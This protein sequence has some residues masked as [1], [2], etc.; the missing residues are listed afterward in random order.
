MISWIKKL[1]ANRYAKS[2][3][4]YAIAVM[5]GVLST[6]IDLPTMPALEEL[7]TFIQSALIEFL[8][9]NKEQL[10]ELL[11]A[12]LMAWLGTWTVAKNR[13]NAKIEKNLEKFGVKVK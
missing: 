3:A 2:I 13:A 5:I 12:I 7:L 9:V 8:D 10:A 1:I 6:Q 4:R 11:T